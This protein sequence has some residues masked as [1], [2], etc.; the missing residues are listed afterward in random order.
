VFLTKVVETL[1]IR[2]LSN[3]HVPQVLE[4]KKYI[5]NSNVIIADHSWRAI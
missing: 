5:T 4:C 2:L 3:A 1:K